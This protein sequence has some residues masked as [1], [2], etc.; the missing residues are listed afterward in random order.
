MSPSSG[1]SICSG[2]E[3]IESSQRS[4]ALVTSSRDTV[5]YYV[6]TECSSIGGRIDDD[7]RD[8]VKEETRHERE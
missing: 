8:R 3:S 1:W 2:T 7:L 6:E 4:H 5:V